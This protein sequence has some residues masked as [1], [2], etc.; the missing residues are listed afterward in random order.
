[1]FAPSAERGLPSGSTGLRRDGDD[2]SRSDL[3]AS[4]LESIAESDFRGDPLQVEL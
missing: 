1:M 2:D 3:A 4:D